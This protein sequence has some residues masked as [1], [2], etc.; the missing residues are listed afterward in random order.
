MKD[1]VS[2]VYF[3]FLT[4]ISEVWSVLLSFLIVYSFNFIDDLDDISIEMDDPA[5][6]TKTSV[7]YFLTQLFV[8]ISEALAFL[9]VYLLLYFLF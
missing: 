7:K 1:S 6:Q 4:V 3:Y 9:V 5:I 2:F 8:V